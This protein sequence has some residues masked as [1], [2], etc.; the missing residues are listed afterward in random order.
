MTWEEK[1]AACQVLGECSLKMRKPGDW[2]VSHRAV[3]V[4]DR[5]VREGGCVSNA[6]TPE[7]AV[8]QHWKWLTEYATGDKY[9]MTDAYGTGRQGYQ[10]RGYMWV[11]WTKT[12]A[13]A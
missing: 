9:V 1:L 8:E 12:E 7:E 13:S 4:K 11:P 2:Y 5:A 10:W 3:E 6:K